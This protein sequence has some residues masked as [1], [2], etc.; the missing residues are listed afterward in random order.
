MP[1]HTQAAVTVSDGADS[2][3]RAAGQLMPA[4]GAGTPGGDFP[5]SE[6]DIFKQVAAAAREAPPAYGHLASISPPTEEFPGGVL[7]L[8]PCANAFGRQLS[9]ATCSFPQAVGCGAPPV[10]FRPT[11]G[12]L[13]CFIELFCF[14]IVGTTNPCANFSH[15]AP[16]GPASPGARAPPSPDY[17][18]PTSDDEEEQPALNGDFNSGHRGILC[19]DDYYGMDVT[20]PWLP[21]GGDDSIADIFTRPLPQRDFFCGIVLPLRGGH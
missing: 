13:A 9:A 19:V 10:G 14:G 18:P 1:P 5:I 2:A 20:S 3:P 21:S 8:V 6:H 16:P 4:A 12:M 15:D 7:E 11:F 17:T